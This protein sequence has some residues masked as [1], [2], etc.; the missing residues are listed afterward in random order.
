MEQ[1]EDRGVLL[2][3]NVTNK[4]FFNSLS[5]FYERV[6]NINQTIMEY[7]ME[8]NISFKKE[9]FAILVEDGIVEEMTD[10]VFH[11]VNN[12]QFFKEEIEIWLQK[13]DCH[14]T[15]LDEFYKIDVEEGVFIFEIFNDLEKP[16]N[17]VV[18]GYIIPNDL[19]SRMLMF[20]LINQGIFNIKE[21]V[22]QK[23]F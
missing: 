18:A 6:K 20:S 1:Q 23:G 4:S 7:C 9:F 15:V 13:S 21:K 8:K 5:Y 11:Q 16:L 3:E 22:S 2:P 17:K 12:I 19:Q 10:S 14:V